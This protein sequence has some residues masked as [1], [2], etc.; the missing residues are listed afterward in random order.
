[1]GVGEAYYDHFER[2]FGAP[3]GRLSGHPGPGLP[4][5][6]V[7][8]YGPL[9]GGRR[10]FCTLGMSHFAPE[11]G[12][13]AEACAVAD[14]GWDD[15][16]DVLGAAVSY[17]VT[18]PH[19]I[20]SG[21]CFSG[22]ERLSPRFAAAFGK[23]VLYFTETLGAPDTLGPVDI[24]HASEAHGRF[25]HVYLAVPITRAEP[26][27][28]GEPGPLGFEQALRDRGADVFHL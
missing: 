18:H 27:Y 19:P 1:M 13:L 15:L 8:S 20:A 12:H 28:V 26:P 21:S 16:P 10:A 6:Q 3:T 9:P 2:L 7:L 25:G 14:D 22:V 4:L 17:M 5:L 11:W 24:G 23:P